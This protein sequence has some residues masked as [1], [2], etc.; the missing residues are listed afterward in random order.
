V[1]WG[2]LGA[3]SADR[4]AMHLEDALYIHGLVY[5]EQESMF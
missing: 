5:E 4:H 1:Y 2:I 3:G